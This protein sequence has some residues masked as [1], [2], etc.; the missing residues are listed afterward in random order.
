M[1][2]VV[3]YLSLAG[4]FVTTGERFCHISFTVVVVLRL[5]HSP[6]I[7]LGFTILGEIFVFV[8]VS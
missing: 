3:L 6:A 4:V 7:S 2:S 8:T 5:L 1:T